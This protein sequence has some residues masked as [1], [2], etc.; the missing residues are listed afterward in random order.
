MADI[1]FSIERHIGVLSE[2]KNWS[3]QLN[4]VSW[5][6]REGKYDLRD[7]DASYA[8]MGKGVTLTVDEVKKLRDLLNTLDLE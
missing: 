7:W 2:A 6:N 4:I 8:K 5:N 1:V 3:K